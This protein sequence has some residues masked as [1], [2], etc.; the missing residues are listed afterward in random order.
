MARKG[1]LVASMILWLF[2]CSSGSYATILTANSCSSSD[3]Q[4]VINSATTGDT[5][6]VPGGSC[7]WSAPVDI[8]STI[9]ITVSGGG[10]TTITSPIG[11]TLEQNAS[12]ES[13]ITGFTFTG[14]STNPPNTAIQVSGST[15]SFAF[16]LDHNTFNNSNQVIF[17]CVSGNGPGLIDNNNFT[18][19]GASEMIHN[20]GMGPSDPSGW[21]DNVTPGSANMVFIEDNTFTFN[22]TGNPAYYWGTSAAQS[23]YGARTVFRYN[24]CNMCQVDQHGTAGM[25]GARWWEIYNNTFNTGVPNANQSSYIVVRDGT[26]VIFN[27]LH[28]GVNQ[29]SGNIELTE[30]ATSG[31]YPLT[32]QIGRGINQD[33]SPSYL[34]GNGSDMPVVSGNMAY[35]NAGVDYFV[36]AT[37]PANMVR[38]ELSAD[39]GTAYGLQGT[40]PATY[41]YTPYT[42]PHPLQQDQPLAPTGLVAAVN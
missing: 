32:Y 19:G 3:V 28:T 39:G 12:A 11:F 4:K 31:Q 21:S 41:S 37:Q 6:V 27:N 42:Y 15:S 23:Y 25:I 35:V 24:T 5:V 38:C 22:A 26:G 2:F 8:P 10:N 1:R 40:C 36:S 18:G 34:W 14:A 17:I 20:L 7:S 33:Y 30:D 13:R 16:R 29:A 9:G